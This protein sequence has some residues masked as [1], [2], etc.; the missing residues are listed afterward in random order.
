M[1]RMP[2]LF[3]A[4]IAI[5]GVTARVPAQAAP[6]PTVLPVLREAPAF[7]HKAAETWLNTA[8]LTWAALRGRVVL[9]EVWTFAC[10]NCI[11]SIPWLRALLDRLPADQFLMLG[12]HTPELPREYALENVRA[13]LRE[14]RISFPVMV[15]NDYSYW[16][17]LGNRY[18]PAFY[19]VD[20]RGR[21]RGHYIGE[22]HEGDAR[23]LRIEAD[24]RRVLAEP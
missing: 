3:L 11:R 24:I 9:L 4:L 8:P 13:K 15:D 2:L 23:A 14:Y 6:K 18:W 17:A 12:V 1:S 19:L 20:R 5:A 10:G 16:N 22:T 21:I 7:T